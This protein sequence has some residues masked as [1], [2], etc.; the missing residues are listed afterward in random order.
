MNNIPDFVMQIKEVEKQL[1]V[2]CDISAEDWKDK[3]QDRF[4]SK[5]FDQ[6]FSSF[7]TYIKG[8][9]DICSDGLNDFLIKINEMLQK[10]EKLTGIP[11]DVTFAMASGV[12]CGDV[13]LNNIGET[14]HVTANAAVVA[15]DGIVHNERHERDYWDNNDSIFSD[16]TRPGEYSHDEIEEIMDYR[17]KG[18]SF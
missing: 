5:F 17:E 14:V 9:S 18:D 10:M 8:G 4:Y 2:Q 13:V 15:R 11:A 1:R 6:Y 3:T 12:A 7:E 16:G